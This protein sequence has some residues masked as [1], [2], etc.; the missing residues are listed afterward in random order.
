MTGA[1]ERASESYHAITMSSISRSSADAHLWTD[2][3]ESHGTAQGAAHDDAE[4]TV[5]PTCPNM[6]PTEF[7]L[8]SACSRPPDLETEALW[9]EPGHTRFTD[10][11]TRTP[12][13][14]LIHVL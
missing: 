1:D 3:V 4:R 5:T 7:L 9:V 12:D 8:F 11:R 10:T 6:N 13:C 14:V 2:R